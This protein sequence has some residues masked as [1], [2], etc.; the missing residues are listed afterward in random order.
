VLGARTD[1]SAKET[2]TKAKSGL[3]YIDQ[4][5]G[6]GEAPKPGDKVAVHYTGW[7]AKSDGKTRGRQ[8]D[9]SVDRGHPFVFPIGK[10]LVI[11]G[12]DEGVAT[13]RV[14]GKRT[15]MIPPDLAYGDNGA[16]AII[17]PNATL[18]FDIEL[19]DIKK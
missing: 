13:M 12:W 17:P 18:I 1:L 4:R 7:L 19:L 9:S 3:S 5:Q 8:F 16:G 11:A 14:G 10:G 6:T 15:L 2:P